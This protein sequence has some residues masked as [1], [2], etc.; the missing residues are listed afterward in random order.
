MPTTKVTTSTK[1][2]QEAKIENNS[3]ELTPEWQ[4][5]ITEF[6]E[7][8]T[9]LNELKK[10]KE[11]LEAEIKDFLDRNEADVATVDGKVRLEV[12]RRTRKGI[13]RNLLFEAYPEAYNATETESSYVVIVAK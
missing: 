10:K 4:A 9:L 2:V 5:L 11:A 8:R 12:S 13:D 1:V 6:I 7:H 3:V